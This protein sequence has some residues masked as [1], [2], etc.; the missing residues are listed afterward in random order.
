MNLVLSQSE[1]DSLL[2]MEKH[3]TNDGRIR[4]PDTGGSVA[5]PLVSPDGT[6]GFHLDVSRSRLNLTKGKFQNRSRTT[7]V[8]A[9]I[10]IGGAPHRNPDDAE[11]ACPHIHLYREGF[12]DRW[13]FPVNDEQ[14]ANTTDH[15]Q[16]LLDFLRYCNVTRPPEFERGLFT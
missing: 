8:L 5:V 7:V 1:A 11:I 3:R 6:E 12:G 2:R 9:R 4:L 14:F 10:D 16:T 15:W 13:A